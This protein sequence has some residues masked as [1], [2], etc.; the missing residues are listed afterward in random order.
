M[1]LDLE[2]TGSEPEADPVG[3]LTLIHF[4]TMPVGRELMGSSTLNGDSD[5]VIIADS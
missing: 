1:L 4:A 2:A 5:T 3:I